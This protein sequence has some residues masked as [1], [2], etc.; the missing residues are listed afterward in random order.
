MRSVQ[1]TLMKPQDHK[2]PAEKV[3]LGAD[4]ANPLVSASHGVAQYE[5][6]ETTG[7]GT[8][9]VVGVWAS[10]CL[11]QSEPKQSPSQTICEVF[12]PKAGSENML[13]SWP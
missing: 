6:C 10:S 9:M 1:R 4:I 13:R 8:V 3:S 5:G 7:R 12:N 11:G 2:K